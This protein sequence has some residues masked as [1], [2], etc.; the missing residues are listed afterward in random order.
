MGLLNETFRR[1]LFL[2]LAEPIFLRK[3]IPIWISLFVDRGF[4]RKNGSDT[5]RIIRK[6]LVVS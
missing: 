5:R 3:T 4:S 2:K 1:L 6:T